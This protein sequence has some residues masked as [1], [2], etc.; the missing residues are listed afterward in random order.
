MQ[1]MQMFLHYI[2][3][4]NNDSIF[5]DVNKTSLKKMPILSDFYA[6]IPNESLY[7]NIKLVLDTWISGSC[8]NMNG[9]TNVDLNNPYIV[10]DCD[11]D[12]LTCLIVLV[13]AR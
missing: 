3:T 13:K 10:F 12:M 8:K 4:D 2:E 7:E 1:R 11:E 9:Q 6:A 5:A